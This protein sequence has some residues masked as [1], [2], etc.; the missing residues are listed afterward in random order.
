MQEIK[1]IWSAGG[2]SKVSTWTRRWWSMELVLEVASAFIGMGEWRIDCS[3]RYLSR[4]GGTAPPPKMSC[5]FV[6]M[7]T[8]RVFSR[9][10]RKTCWV[11]QG[12]NAHGWWSYMKKNR[13]EAGMPPADLW[14][15]SHILT[16][17]EKEVQ[18]VFLHQTHQ[19]NLFPMSY[20]FACSHITPT[21]TLN[22]KVRLGQTSAVE[23]RER[24]RQ[25][26]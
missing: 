7:G 4:V 13:M 15:W 2:T 22:L 10:L 6:T 24:G 12:N 9:S 19:K 21:L 1:S 14:I 25:F 18:Y 11:A 23:R 26:K 16:L 20:V 8:I 17:F 5:A 3:Y